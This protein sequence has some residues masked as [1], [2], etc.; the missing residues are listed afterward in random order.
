M[1]DRARERK[2]CQVP[3]LLPVTVV[4]I[5]SL[6]LQAPLPPTTKRHQKEIYTH[7]TCS[8]QPMRGIF[9]PVNT[10]ADA[11]KYQTEADL[12]RTWAGCGPDLAWNRVGFHH[13]CVRSGIGML[14]DF[15]QIGARSGPVSAACL[16]DQCQTR[17]KLVTNQSE[18][19]AKSGPDQCQIRTKLVPNQNQISAKSGPDQDQMS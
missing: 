10:G 19:S 14:L 7:S 15:Y 9:L 18:I 11:V 3:C 4:P 13:I 17:V 16:P 1:S 6:I 8:A 12:G 2:A 5:A